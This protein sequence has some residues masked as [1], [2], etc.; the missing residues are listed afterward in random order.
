MVVSALMLGSLSSVAVADKIVVPRDHRTIQE[1]VDAANDG[2]TIVVNRGTYRENVVIDGTRLG[3]NNLI[4]KGKGQ[5]K[6]DGQGNDALTIVDATGI[7]VLGMQFRNSDTGVIVDGCTNITLSKITSSGNSDLGVR[8]RNSDRVTIE[9]SKF[10]DNEETAIDLDG[11]NCTIDRCK[12]SGGDRGLDLGGDSNTITS[13]S[14]TTTGGEGL[15]TDGDSSNFTVTKNTFNGTRDDAMD[16]DGT[17][18]RLTDNTTKKAQGDGIRVAGEDILIEGG[19]HTK[20]TDDGVL[21]FATASNVT[22]MGLKII[23][24]GGDGVHIRGTGHIIDGC[25]VKKAKGAS[26]LNREAGN[27]YRNNKAVKS[28]TFDFQDFLFEGI[29]TL[30]NNQF[31]PDKLGFRLN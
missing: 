31:D 23:G 8:V 16:I 1:A 19:K 4:L 30:E 27:V 22:L 18:H 5:P 10:A 29:T 7:Q 13:N 12:I 17:G 20:P 6:L 21:F 24:P 3:E 25:Q 26:F 28:R 2:D 15:E 11:T 9:R 14:I